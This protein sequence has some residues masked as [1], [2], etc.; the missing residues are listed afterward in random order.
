[1]PRQSLA[2]GVEEALWRV[3]PMPPDQ[4]VAAWQAEPLAQ[5]GWSVQWGICRRN[6]LVEQLERLGLSDKAQVY[7]LHNGAVFPVRGD[8][9]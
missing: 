7:L 3:S 4:I 1:M 8:A 2:N 9:W 6:T 5:G